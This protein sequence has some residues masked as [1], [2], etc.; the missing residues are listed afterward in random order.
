MAVAVAQ[1]IESVQPVGSQDVLEI[2]RATMH[3]IQRGSTVVIALAPRNGMAEIVIGDCGRVLPARI[4]G[5]NAA[6]I[7]HVILESLTSAALRIAIE[8]DRDP[9]SVNETRPQPPEESK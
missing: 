3:E 5:D 6:T 9:S 4:T 8:N 7:V 2:I 1:P